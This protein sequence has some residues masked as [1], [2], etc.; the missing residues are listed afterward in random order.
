MNPELTTQ[1]VDTV[2]N[3]LKKFE[4][5]LTIGQEPFCGILSGVLRIVEN[6]TE[7]SSPV[8]QAILWVVS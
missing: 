4:E 8:H 1:T 6:E 3:S 5:S 7:K 2:Q